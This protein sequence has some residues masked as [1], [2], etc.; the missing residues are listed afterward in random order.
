MTGTINAL[1]GAT[2]KKMERQQQL[3]AEQ[4]SVAQARQLSLEAQKI[5][6]DQPTRRNPRG[7]RLF[8]DAGKSQLPSTVA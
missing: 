6:T 2:A 3:A 8:A 7:R 4:Q 1:T 5:A